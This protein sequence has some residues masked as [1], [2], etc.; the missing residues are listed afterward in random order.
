MLNSEELKRYD[1]HI[2]LQEVGGEGQ[3]ELKSAK[4]LVIGAGGLG[5]PVLQYLTAAGVGKIG[6]IDGDIVSL[7]NLQR[8]VLFGHSDIGLPKVEVAI[9]KLKDLN[10]FV[11]FVVYNEFLTVDNALSVVSQ[12]DIVIDGSDNFSTRYLANDACVI[13]KKPLVFGSIFKFEGQVSVFNYQGGASYRCLYPD[14]PKSGQVPN[15]SEV[16]VLGVLPGLVGTM[17]ANECLKMILEIGKVSSGKVQLVNL[18]GDLFNEIK[19]T[20]LDTNFERTSLEE[21]YELVC[22]EPTVKEKIMKSITVDEL[23]KRI[24]SGEEI[25]LID[26]REPFEYEICAIAKS[27]L[28]SL[29][30]IPSNL[31]KIKKDIPVVFICHHGM[32]SASAIHFA[33]AE[34]FDNLINLTGGIDAWAREVDPSMEIY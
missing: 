22:E 6:V 27:L 23:D 28:I 26:V 5:C 11:D 16:G 20:R 21:N 24:K 4:V 34:G 8:Q 14:V 17:M 32:R 19:F 7:S 1:R 13:M 9:R 29:N 3:S 10:P 33:E 18:L 31:D 15:C 25:Q 30:T 2:R 12:Y